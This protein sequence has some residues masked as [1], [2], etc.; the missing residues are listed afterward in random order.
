MSRCNTLLSR[1]LIL[2]FGVV[3]A[4]S[5]L[6]AQTRFVPDWHAIG[7]TL[8][9][10]G[11]PSPASGPVER[12][13][14]AGDGERLVFQLPD[15]R[16]FASSDLESWSPATDAPPLLNRDSVADAEPGA[17]IYRGAN[18][19]A[20]A[21][22]ADLWR[23]S[24]DGHSWDN[25]T[26]Y[27]GMSI[28]GGPVLDVAVS[29]TVRNRVVAATTTGLWISHD[30]G[31]TW[32]G[33]NELIENLP[34]TR[35]IAPPSGSTGLRIAVG[36]D[37]SPRELEW[38][39]GQRTGWVAKDNP[40]LDLNLRRTLGAMFGATI[41]VVSVAGDAVY[42]GSDGGRLWAS[43]D[44]GQTWRTSGAAS[45]AIAKI[46]LDPSDARFAVAVSSNADGEQRVLR[47]LNGGQ[48]W[49][50]LTANLPAVELRGV[51][52]DRTSGAVYVATSRGIYV[53]IADLRAPAPATAWTPLQGAF[54]SEAVRD[55]MLDSTAARLYAA[56]DYRGVY[57]TPAP[58]R[59]RMPIA[60]HSAD[61]AARAAAPGVLLSVI[62]Q[63]V[64]TAFAGDSPAPVLTATGQESQIQIPYDVAGDTLQLDVAGAGANTLFG[65]PLRQASPAILVD[66]DGT[67]L[68]LDAE[69]G[70]QLDAMNPARGGMRI[71]ILASGLGRVT[72]AWPSGLQA[73]LENAPRVASPV[74]VLFDGTP[75]P[76]SRATL[77]PGYIGYYLV[78]ATLPDFV[79]EGASEL[80]IEAAGSASNRVRVYVGR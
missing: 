57:V 38:M 59:T 61:Y 4:T 26:G 7:N 30:G 77:A 69:T 20:W 41:S 36:S 24:D 3:C 37:S 74:R 27:K 32:A 63:R 45:G 19:A 55:V 15:G 58:H 17:R 53:T 71:Q 6:A 40:P 9:L 64:E 31:A 35:L 70:V 49:D 46:W 52:A 43:I 47:T 39:P 60:V 48:F 23:S 12:V 33:L 79:D 51:T 76:V 72:P 80:L 14:Y 50:D 10:L 78:E 1:A 21:A 44:G 13:W 5:P 22:G 42:A 54:E 73:P 67:P 66:R 56:L 34:V 25:V 29:P 75:L 8:Q 11:L 65:L 2:A 16:K 28:L 62:G 68:L 18:G